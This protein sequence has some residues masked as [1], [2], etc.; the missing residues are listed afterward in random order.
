[1]A[2]IA[3]TMPRMVVRMNPLRNHACDEPD[4]NRPDDA[5]SS[6]EY[7]GRE[8]I[9]FDAVYVLRADQR[10]AP[11]ATSLADVLTDGERSDLPLADR[12]AVQEA[13]AS[14]ADQILLAAATRLV[15]EIPKVDT[16][17]IADEVV[18][19]D[20]RGSLAA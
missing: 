18:V 14:S 13:S 12:E 4:D 10:V 11:A 2:T 17:R 7:A 5:Q 16:R 15:R 20:H 19:S 3:P 6:S 8:F 9:H 1:M